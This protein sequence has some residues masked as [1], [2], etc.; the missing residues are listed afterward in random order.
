MVAVQSCMDFFGVFSGELWH[1]MEGLLTTGV[2]SLVSSHFVAQCK[3]AY[4]AAIVPPARMAIWGQQCRHMNR[5]LRLNAS[6]TSP[7][8]TRQ[9]RLLVL[10]ACHEQQ[11]AEDGQLD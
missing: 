5:P 10:G 6:A 3:M 8:C 9:C 7:C 4:T 2:H 11:L 1:G